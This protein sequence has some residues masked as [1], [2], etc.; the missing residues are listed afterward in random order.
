MGGKAVNE[1]EK[2]REVRLAI[3]RKQEQMAQFQ[4]FSEEIAFDFGSVVY[5]IARGRRSP[6]V[7]NIRTSDRVLFHAA[8]PGATPDN[9]EWVRRKSNVVL[10]YHQSSLQFGD[11]L[12]LKGRIINPDMG[13]D[14]MN[15]A[16]H[17]GSFPI[18]VKKAGV[19]AAVTVS[20]LPQLDDHRMIV[21]ALDQYLKIE[22][23]KF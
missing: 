2:E 7:V 4:G 11:T 16:G 14:M 21:E 20:G 22:L 19:V 8:M 12:A 23:P 17:G 1:V 10:R 13:I 3:L 18:R 6:V 15:F 5:G 9:D